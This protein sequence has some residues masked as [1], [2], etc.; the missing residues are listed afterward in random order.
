MAKRFWKRLAQLYAAL[1]INT[2]GGKQMFAAV[3][4][5]PEERSLHTFPS[6]T[7]EP[8]RCNSLRRYSAFRA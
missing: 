8:K 6:C 3:A 5:K 2:G 4:M 7:S 1:V